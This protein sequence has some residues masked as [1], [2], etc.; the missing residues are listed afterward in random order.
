MARLSNHGVGPVC[1]ALE[2]LPHMRVDVGDHGKALLAADLPK[3]S[4]TLASEDAHAACVGFRVEFV[5]V[6]RLTCKTPATK[7]LSQEEGAALMPALAAAN[8]LIAAI[9]PKVF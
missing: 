6:D 7:L 2:R 1:L 9:A 3:L 5:V 8:Q 4:K